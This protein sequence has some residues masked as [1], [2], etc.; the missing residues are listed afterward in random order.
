LVDATFTTTEAVP[1]DW[2]LD[3]PAA[4]ADARLDP[5]PATARTPTTATTFAGDTPRL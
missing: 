2:P 5:R 1:V 4:T 3:H